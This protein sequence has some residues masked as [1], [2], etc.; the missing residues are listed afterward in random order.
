MLSLLLLLGLQPDPTLHDRILELERRL[1]AG[2]HQQDTSRLEP[3]LADDFVLRGN[4]DVDRATW[5]RNAVTLCWG[6]RSEIDA[7]EARR[8]GDAVVSSFVLTLYQDPRTC[9]PATIRSLV[10]SI[11]TPLDGG[12]RLAVRHSGPA[13]EPGTDPLAHQFLQEEPPPPRWEGA[14]ELSFVST[15]GNAEVQTLGASSQ[16]IYRPGIW[17]TS[18]NAAFVRS[19]AEGV[20]NARSLGIQLRQAR[21]VSPRLEVFGR[22]GYRR[23]LFAGIEHRV[24]SDFGLGYKALDTAAHRLTLD[25]GL[26][27]LLEERLAGTRLTSA[28][29]NAVETWRWQIRDPVLIAN[30]GA[31]TAPLEEAQAWRLNNQLSLTTSLTDTFSVKISH[32]LNYLN[33]P[34]PGFR[35]TDSIV[36]A[37]LVAKFERR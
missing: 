14:A 28:I 16:V 36:A 20:E 26:G 23:D 21:E 31:F 29:I 4:P 2:L 27:Y 9:E 12:W 8:A 33:R 7:F 22:G 11:W 34:V 10:T 18:A 24:S 17:E 13:G 3:L 5:I 1:V 37:A 25:L 35:R 32:T 6:D 30:D 19:I 15:A